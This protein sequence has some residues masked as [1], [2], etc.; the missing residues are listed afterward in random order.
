MGV[1]FKLIPNQAMNGGG[2]GGGGVCGSGRVDR[3]C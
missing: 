2:G 1:K 3:W